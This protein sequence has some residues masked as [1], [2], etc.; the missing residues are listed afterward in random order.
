MVDR[1]GCFFSSLSL[2]SCFEFGRNLWASSGERGKVCARLKLDVFSSSSCSSSFTFNKR[3]PIVDCLQTTIL[4]SFLVQ[5]KKINRNC[6]QIRFHSHYSCFNFPNNKIT[7]ELSCSQN[8][9]F[10]FLVLIAFFVVFQFDHSNITICTNGTLL[11]RSV[12]SITPFLLP[13]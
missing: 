11:P 6:R 12:R 13:T 3:R 4:F 8:T 1:V 10:T 7:K 5:F 9:P 2:L